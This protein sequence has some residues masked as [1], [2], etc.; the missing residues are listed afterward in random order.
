MTLGEAETRRQK[1]IEFLERIGGDADKFRD[2]IAAEYAES[3]G[4]KLMATNQRKTN[5]RNRRINVMARVA[6]GPTKGE[7]RATL[8][9][10]AEILTEADDAALTREEVIDKVREAA[11]LASGEEGGEEAEPDDE[12]E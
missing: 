12:E 9:E 8:D 10:I 6:A 7:L 3:K 11:Q 1:A 4:V 2:M 5:Q